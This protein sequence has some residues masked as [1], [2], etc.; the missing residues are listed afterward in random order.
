[1]P[2][3]LSRRS[4]PDGT[5]Y[6]PAGSDSRRYWRN[7]PALTGLTLTSV[8][9]FVP[10]AFLDGVPGV[11]FRAFSDDD[12]RLAADLAGDGRY[13]HASLAGWIIR[14]S[15]GKSVK[16][17][18]KAARAPGVLAVYELAVRTALRHRWI[19]MEICALLYLRDRP[20]WPAR[21]RLSA[22]IG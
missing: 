19:T 9:V 4:I 6:A 5:G 3:S 22:Q 2:S 14:V 15:H 11:F 13:A 20:L 10:L 1:M 16:R 7:L 8:V 12:D 17:S 18:R 21:I